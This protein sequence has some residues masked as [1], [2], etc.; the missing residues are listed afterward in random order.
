MRDVKG[1]VA[2]VTGSA[3][4][5]GRAIAGRFAAAGMKVVLADVE[6]GALE[7]AEAELRSEGFPV[8]AVQTDVSSTASVE[9][10]AQRTISEFGAVHV[11]CN[12]A[13]VGGVGQ[14]AWETPPP[15]WEWML[16]VNL[17]GVVNGVR[18]FLPILVAQGE[19]HVVNTSSMAGLVPGVSSTMYSASKYA[20]TGLSEGIKIELEALGSPVKI[21]VLVP[22]AVRTNLV[23]DLR[24]WPAD[25]GTPPERRRYDRIGALPIPPALQEMMASKMDPA[26]VGQLVL[27]GVRADRFW[28]V[29][30][31]D[32]MR[33]LMERRTAYFVEE[34]SAASS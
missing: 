29:T 4:G 18:T 24:N 1:K 21:S 11:V 13:G 6:A 23:N 7:Q 27:D 30:H 33:E 5:M 16:R 20:V 14:M 8:L 17:Q 32:A 31:P 3:S 19:G 26:E 34:L 9:S 22:G 12:N 25:L 28:I 10:L 15:A 2:V